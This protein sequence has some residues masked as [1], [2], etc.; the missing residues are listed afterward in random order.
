MVCVTQKENTEILATIS[1]FDSGL[2]LLH[3]YC[4]TSIRDQSRRL[5]NDVGLLLV[6]SVNFVISVVSSLRVCHFRVAV[7]PASPWYTRYVQLSVLS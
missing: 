2:V 5:E 6:D 1:M 7:A 3:T 4:L